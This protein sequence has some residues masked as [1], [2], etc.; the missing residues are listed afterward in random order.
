MNQEA[1]K[2]PEKWTKLTPDESHII[3][4]KGTERPFSG[5]YDKNF[6]DG[7]YVCKRCHAPLYRA[8][9]KFNAHC[10][11]PSFDQEITGAVKRVNDADGQRVEILCNN[12]GAHLGHVFVGENLTAKNTRHCVN[13]ISMVFIPADKMNQGNHDHYSKAYFASGCYWGTEYFRQSSWCHK[14]YS[15]LYGGGYPKSQL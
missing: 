11:W 4:N 12:C 15:G 2:D 9:D 1:L 8:A 6:S 13:S 7:I 5:E 3:V 10:G 14:N